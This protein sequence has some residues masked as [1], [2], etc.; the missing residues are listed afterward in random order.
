MSDIPVEREDSE[1]GGRYIVHLD[2]LEAEMTYSRA[3]KT[4]LIIDHTDVPKELGGRG[5]GQRML[6]QL[7]ADARTDNL[8][9]IPLCPFAKAQFD[10]HPEWADILKS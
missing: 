3:G 4:I 6:Q 10:N 9:I 2:G 8:K 7:I 1:T 5:V